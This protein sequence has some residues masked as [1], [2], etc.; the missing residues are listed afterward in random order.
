[1]NCLEFRREVFVDPRRLSREAQAHASGC[2]TCSQFHA[3]TSKLD[4]QIHAALAVGVPDGL[5]ERI[6]RNA[7]RGPVET[8][9]R[10]MALAASLLLASGAGAGVYIAKRDSPLARAG[11]DFV[12]DKEVSAILQAKPSDPSALRGVAQALN[13]E[14]PQQ[15]GEVRYIGTCP[16]Q[17]TIAH[18]VVIMTPEGKATLLL[19][20]RKLVGERRS[21]AARGLRAVVM[22][23]GTGSL[24]I[25]ADASGLD[26]IERMVARG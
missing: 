19:I 18:H 2:A 17:N 26:R 7:T 9:R 1:M 15:I 23:A 5:A 6:S 25:I 20:P 22:P 14:L 4:E 24:A 21:A 12:I 3:D 10:F 13:V 8:R 11:I 16:F